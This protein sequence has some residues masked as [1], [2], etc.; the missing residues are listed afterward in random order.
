MSTITRS[1]YNTLLA[2]AKIKANQLDQT[3]AIV[4][5]KDGTESKLIACPAA[6]NRN[7]PD[8]TRVNALL[9]K[10]KDSEILE[11]VGPNY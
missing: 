1:T 8:M 11:I 7:E 3:V 2:E 10:Q 5:W 4:T 9:A 6:G